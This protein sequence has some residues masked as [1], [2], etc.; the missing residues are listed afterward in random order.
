[1]GH[2]DQLTW[3]FTSHEMC[4]MSHETCHLVYIG[5]LSTPLKYSCDAPPVFV[6]LAET[7]LNPAGK[8]DL[9]RHPGASTTKL[10]LAEMFLHGLVSLFTSL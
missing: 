7:R 2:L 9:K 6:G 3:S 5:S 4:Q 8:R 10:R 1:M